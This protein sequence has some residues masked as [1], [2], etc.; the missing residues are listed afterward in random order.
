[1]ASGRSLSVSC[2][3]GELPEPERSPSPRR[4][5][6]AVVRTLGHDLLDLLLGQLGMRLGGMRPHLLEQLR[7]VIGLEVAVAHGAV[8]LA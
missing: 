6:V 7:V 1:M 2:Q 5:S 8:D 3:R 4:R